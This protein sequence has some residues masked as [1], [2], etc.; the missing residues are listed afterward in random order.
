MISKKV[1]YYTVAWF[2]RD[3]PYPRNG[4][5]PVW[6]S[7]YRIEVL[8]VCRSDR[9][10]AHAGPCPRHRIV[11]PEAV[12]GQSWGG[13]L[14][15]SGFVLQV[16]LQG[17]SPGFG[18]PGGKWRA[19]DPHVAVYQHALPASLGSI[20]LKSSSFLPSPN[21]RGYLSGRSN[22]PRRVATRLASASTV[23]GLVAKCH[24]APSLLSACILR[25]VSIAR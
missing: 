23:G 24:L 15:R 9:E 13:I 2:V 8:K 19:S 21:G 1:P 6:S 20:N 22:G 11:W 10:E 12:S 18:P 4:G 16:P 3:S 17:F 14:R 5:Y 25:S 7:M